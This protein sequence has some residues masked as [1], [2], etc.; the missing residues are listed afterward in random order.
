VTHQYEGL[1]LWADHQPD[2]VPANHP[3]P[4]SV[5]LGAGHIVVGTTIGGVD[6]VLLTFKAGKLA[7][8]LAEAQQASRSSRPKS[9]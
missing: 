2:T 7:Q 5:E 1:P 9:G 4:D 6:K 8:K 3:N